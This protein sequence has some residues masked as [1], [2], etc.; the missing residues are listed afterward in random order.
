MKVNL[1]KRTV[2]MRC[3]KCGRTF[4]LSAEEYLRTPKREVPI[5]PTCK[6]V[7][8]KKGGKKR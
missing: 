2:E 8:R 1:F 7:T 5:C 6:G 4:T 3:V